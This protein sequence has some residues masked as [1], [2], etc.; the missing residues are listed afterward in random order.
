MQR[1]LATWSTAD[2]E[3]KF[4]R[5]LRII[6]DRSW[7]QEAARI[8]LA[9]SG[10]KTPGIDGVSKHAL[11][12]VLPDELERLRGELLSG[13]YQP[14]PARRVYIP[15]ANGKQRPLGIPTLRDRI[16]QR[17]M[18][19]VM[20]PIWESDFHRLS[21]G[22]RPELSVHHAIRT[23]KLQLQESPSGRGRWIIEG[24]LASYFDTVHHR[25]LMRSL[26]KRICDQRFLNLIWKLINAGHV[27][28]GLFCAASEGV[29]QGGVISPLLSNIMLNE[30]DQ[31]L[32]TKY[33]SK[34]VRKDRWAWNFGIQ[35][36]RPIAVRENRQWKPAVAYCRYADDFVVIVK[37]TKTDAAAIREEC[38]EFL[39]GELM[40]TLNL[41]KTHVTHVNDGFVFLGHRIIRK[42]GPRGTMHVVTTI[43][44]E[45]Q[46][47]FAA[48]LTKALSGNY[49][50]NKIDRVEQLNRQLAGWVNFYR[51]TDYTAIVFG[52]LDRVVF[53]KL[54]HWLARKYRTSVKSLIRRWVK[55]PD[56]GVAKTWVLFGRSGK[57]NLCGVTLL[58]LVTSRKSQFRWRN[59][60]G[61]PHLRV[62]DGRS[63]VTSRYPDV[64]MAFSHS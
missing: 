64:A 27:D 46:R 53:W 10:A 20:E 43:P 48:K 25:L 14:A 54:A 18:L 44:R 30:F 61:N 37:G 24:D 56:T 22:F 21:Y 57:G 40:L 36:G 26:R 38:R 7:L 33:L 15:K 13:S 34:K 29:P 63:T 42:R 3:R 5:L 45:K 55:H 1:K 52:K 16:V 31:W 58:R 60:A 51:F 4:D 23:V 8:S 17:A 6:A 62:D 39:E 32:E 49:S 35:Q 12:A 47:N 50:E 11:L 41:E 19:M 2:S 9:S 28:R 59:P